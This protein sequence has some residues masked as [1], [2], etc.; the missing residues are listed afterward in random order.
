MKRFSIIA[1][2]ITICGMT[3]MAQNRPDV[4]HQST[5]DDREKYTPVMDMPALVYDED[6]QEIFVEGSQSNY[7]MVSITMQPTQMVVLETMID[8]TFDIIDVSS[9]VAG[10]YTITL[11]SSSWNNYSWTFTF[12]GGLSHIKTTGKTAKSISNANGDRFN[13][14]E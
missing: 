8:G 10:N 9:L 3:A 13:I 5:G 2:L 12:D 6:A 7:Y 4:T 1:I 14:R 11:T